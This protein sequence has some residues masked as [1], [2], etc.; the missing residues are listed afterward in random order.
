MDGSSPEPPEPPEPPESTR[1]PAPPAAGWAL[2]QSFLQVVREGSLSGAAR[3]LA[4]TQPTIGRHIDALEAALG[5]ALFTRSQRGLAPTETALALAPHAA[6]MANA[7]EALRRTASGEAQ[8]ARGSIRITASEIVGSEVLPGM[9]AAFRERHPRIA[10]EVLLSNRS[11]DLLHREAD[12]AVRM[13]RPTQ[14]AL[15][16]R[17]VGTVAIGLHAHRDYVERH[18]MPASLDDL[19]GHALIGFDRAPWS[20]RLPGLGIEPTREMFAFRSDQDVAQ[21]AALKAGFGLGMCQIPLAARYP[22][23][24]RVLP[25]RLEVDLEIWVVMHEDLRTSLR[26]RLMF[27]HLAEALQAYAA[28]PK[29]ADG[30][31]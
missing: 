17:R 19:G 4:L 25:G 10:V 8:E 27:D 28:S 20:R 13:I 29:T 9:L 23:L 7:A 12:I 21:L 11:E 6:A 26:M 22:E 30:A 15:V 14:A 2:Y 24:V 16:A 3:V 1:T 31:S 18:G 5:V